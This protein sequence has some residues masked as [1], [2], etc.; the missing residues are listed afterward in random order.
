M[1]VFSPERRG[2]KISGSPWGEGLGKALAPLREESIS[3]LPSATPDPKPF[4]TDS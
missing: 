2:D 1:R 4:F 3:Y